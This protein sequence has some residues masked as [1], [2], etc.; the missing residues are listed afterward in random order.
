MAALPAGFLPFAY[1]LMA[2]HVL[3]AAVTRSEIRTY[4]DGWMWWVLTA[5]FWLTLIQ[6]PF[7]FLW[8]ATSAEL[9]IRQKVGLGRHDLPRQHV[10]DAVLSLVQVPSDSRRGIAG[11][12]WLNAVT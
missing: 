2:I 4:Q 9:S 1:A 3:L 11:A 12:H 7:C 10:R 6:W 8:V 5:A